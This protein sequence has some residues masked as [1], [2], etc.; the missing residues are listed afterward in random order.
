MPPKKANNP[1]LLLVEGN[2]DSAVI[3][4]LLLRHGYDWEDA[5]RLRPYVQ[6]FD[7]VE[8][9]LAALPQELK[10]SGVQRLG[11]VVDVDAQPGGRWQALCDRVAQAGVALPAQP[12]PDGTRVAGRLPGTE[13]GLWLMPDN[14]TSGTLE[15]FVETLVPAADPCWSDAQHSAR[16][17]QAR[18]GE[19][20]CAEVDLQKSGLYTW[21][22]WQ[23][24]PGRPF[25]TALTAHFLGHDSPQALAF[26]GW[27]QRLFPPQLPAPALS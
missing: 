23:R 20:G 22:A 13:L 18:Y 5:G 19:K 16:Q 2:D 9:L 27:F 11:V 24:E 1:Y 3:R 25:G 26:V 8:K 14:R 6:A 4:H 21:L 7:G 10:S 15:H 17:A 12:D